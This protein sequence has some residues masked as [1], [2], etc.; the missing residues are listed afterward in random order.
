M[1]PLI[2]GRTAET[3]HRTVITVV[4]AHPHPI[5]SRG[6]RALVDAV[7]DLPGLTVRSLYDL[8]PD[9]SIDVEAEQRALAASRLIVWQHPFYWYSVP[10]L[11]KLWF[12]R[13]L[14]HG[15]AYG[16]GGTALRGKDCLWVATTGGPPEWYT[17]Q[18]PHAHPFEA[19]EPPVR[20]TAR[21]CG[22]NW[23]GHVVV[24]GAHRIGA[25]GL[26]AA[27]RGY[28]QRLE[29]YLREHATP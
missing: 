9:F 13:V 25:D 6:G 27:A 5:R 16:E 29:R 12:E 15:W 23:L 22:M 3:A 4:Y 19:F 18:G 14:A 26:A 1:R 8:Y 20:Q 17:P 10:A 24:Q 28:R 11:L 2:L 21:F 7:R